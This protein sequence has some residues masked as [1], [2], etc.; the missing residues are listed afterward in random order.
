M[1][2]KSQIW[3]PDIVKELSKRAVIQ[4]PFGP[5][6]Y[7]ISS[8]NKWKNKIQYQFPVGAPWSICSER[9]FEIDSKIPTMEIFF[10]N[11]AD[12]AIL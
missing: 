1:V 5:K 3:L 11:D 12:L 4:G 6:R 7:R 8:D 2:R 10:S 9:F